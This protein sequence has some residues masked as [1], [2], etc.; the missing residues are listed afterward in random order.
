MNRIQY[1]KKLVFES[2]ERNKFRKKFAFNKTKVS[3]I[4]P[5]NGSKD[6]NIS[7]LIQGLKSLIVS[8]NDFLFFLE[9]FYLIERLIT[10]GYRRFKTDVDLLRYYE[11]YF[12]SLIN[13]QYI[14]NERIFELLDNKIIDQVEVRKLIENKN[15]TY[16]VVR[17]RMD[18]THNWKEIYFRRSL[19]NGETIV[20]YDSPTGSEAYAPK[21]LVKMMSD[22]AY[23][24]D[25]ITDD[26]DRQIFKLYELSEKY[27]PKLAKTVSAP[28]AK[29]L[30]FK[31]IFLKQEKLKFRVQK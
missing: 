11:Y 4:T 31:S 7:S 2:V 20:C 3:S 23:T 17:Y 21:Y 27:D 30:D 29:N 26:L 12:Y 5:L 1:T 18:H 25:K 15:Y 14:F 24:M 8:I 28:V 16:P 9:E 22:V 13:Y 19:R 10:R 6:E